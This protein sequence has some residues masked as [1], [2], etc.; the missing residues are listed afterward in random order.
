[1]IVKSIIFRGNSCKT[2]KIRDFIMRNKH[3]ILFTMNLI[4]NMFSCVII[5]H[6]CLRNGARD[7]SVRAWCSPIYI[8]THR[9]N[10]KT[11]KNH[12]IQETPQKNFKS[13][14]ERVYEFFEG[15]F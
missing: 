7:E 4:E 9:D 13:Y 1:M 5:D 6:R 15:F 3:A 2:H 10:G 11:K 8:C 12:R 14:K